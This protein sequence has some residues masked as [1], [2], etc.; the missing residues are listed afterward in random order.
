VQSFVAGLTLYCIVIGMVQL[1]FLLGLGWSESRRVRRG[2]PPPEWSPQ[3]I[4][5]IIPCLHEGLV[6]GA[7]V[8]ALLA[9][10]PRIQIM[11]VDD[12]STD[13]TATAA[14]ASGDPRVTVLRRRLPEARLGKGP[15]LNH[16]FGAIRQRVEAEG[17]DPEAVIVVVM[18]ADGRLSPGAVDDVVRLFWDDRIGGAQLGVRIRNRR[19]NALTAIQDCEFW[20]IAALGQLGRMRTRTVSLGG[21]GQFTRLSALLSIGEAPWSEALTEDLD[22]AVT[23]SIAGW[24]LTS[25]PHSWVTQQGLTRIRPL[26]RQRTRWFQGH[27][28][29][30]VGRM[31]DV[32]RSKELPNTAVVEMTSYL[33]IPF[34]IVLPWSILS[35]VGLVSV[36]G[37]ITSAGLPAGD[38]GLPGPPW[39]LPALVWYVLSFAPTILCG[40]IYARRE[41]DI[42]FPRAV[43]F[44]HL[45]VLWNYVLFIAC[46]SAVIRMA[47]GRTGWVKTARVAEGTRPAADDRS[48]LSAGAS[49]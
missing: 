27:M 33:L 8:Q 9:Q 6:I 24:H 2:P 18:D 3:A 48:A 49:S 1:A 13:D 22:L 37:N 45:L 42:S 12:A 38:S 28:T 30:A 4:F 16:A 39:L 44:S 17:L 10:D 40:C 21:N 41:D 25:S 23:L 15:A 31:G 20:G 46:W 19:T 11:V 7:T 34:A 14:A 47:R 35:Q 29:T 43:A 32:W 5:A 36:L 26:V